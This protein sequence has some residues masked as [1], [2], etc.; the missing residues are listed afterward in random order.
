MHVVSM[1]VPLFL[2]KVIVGLNLKDLKKKFNIKHQSQVHLIN[3]KSVDPET[4]DKMDDSQLQ[5]IKKK[6]L[7][8]TE[9]KS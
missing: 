9:S 8:L 2:I 4:K 3:T 6:W 1:I 5:K 7:H